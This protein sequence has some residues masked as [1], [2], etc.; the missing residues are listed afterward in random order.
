MHSQLSLSTWLITHFFPLFLSDFFHVNK[1]LWFH[2]IS[3]CLTR[4]GCNFDLESKLIQVRSNICSKVR[5]AAEFASTFLF[6][7]QNEI[8][9][10]PP[11][12]I[13]FL[14][15]LNMTVFGVF[16]EHSEIMQI[17]R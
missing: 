11:R 12:T 8:A 16:L 10:Q 4:L 6:S 14:T 5:Q 17:H 9:P 1:T 2:S 3:V 13:Y 15:H 7:K